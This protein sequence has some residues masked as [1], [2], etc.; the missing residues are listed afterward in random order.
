MLQVLTGMFVDHAMKWSQSDNQKLG[1]NRKVSMLVIGSCQGHVGDTAF[2]A[3]LKH[4][5]R[6]A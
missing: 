6:Q 2:L 4:S 1:A 3:K 5:F